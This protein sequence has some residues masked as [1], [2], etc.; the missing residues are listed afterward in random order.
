MGADARKMAER[1][2]WIKI[3]HSAAHFYN[4]KPKGNFNILTKMAISI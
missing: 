4:T 2:T 1:L 3:R